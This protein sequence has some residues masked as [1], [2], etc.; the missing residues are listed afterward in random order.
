M[1]VNGAKIVLKHVILQMKLIKLV[2][3][4]MVSE[5]NEDGAFNVWVRKP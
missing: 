2:V 1:V 4:I 5:S 3:V